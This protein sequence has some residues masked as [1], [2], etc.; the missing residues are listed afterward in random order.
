MNLDDVLTE[1]Q[2][3]FD[4]VAVPEPA[5]GRAVLGAHVIEAVNPSRWVPPQWIVLTTGMRLRR[6]VPAQ[7][8]LVAELSEGGAVA[9]GFGVGIVFDEIPPALLDEARKRDFAVF[10]VPEHTPFREIVR[11]VD[12]ALLSQDLQT[13]RRSASITDGLVQAL[14]DSPPEPS[15]VVRLSKLLHCDASLYRADGAVVHTSGLVADAE[16]RWRDLRA[17]P[18]SHGPVEVVD[19]DGMFAATVTVDGEISHWLVLGVSRG[20]LAVPLILRALTVATKLL[21]GLL[22]V[23]GGELKRRRIRQAELLLAMVSLRPSASEAEIEELRDRALEFGVDVHQR[24]RVVVLGRPDGDDAQAC[25]WRE[26]VVRALAR[27]RVAHL[28]A[29]H[30]STVAL[31]L[32]AD[33]GTRALVASLATG[34]HPLCAGTGQE[35]DDPGS[36]RASYDGARLALRKSFEGGP[37]TLVGYEE[38][39]LLTWMILEVGVAEAERRARDLLA[40]LHDQEYL[41]ETL[42]EYLRNALSIPATARVLHVHENSV[43]HRLN[44]AKALLGSELTSVPTLAEIHIALLLRPDDGE[45]AQPARKTSREP[46]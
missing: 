45:P 34:D 37:G 1:E 23:R 22:G 15:L 31:W 26:D 28:V 21:E 3:G 10:A 25:R 46:V 44:R 12:G 5:L 36:L 30:E 24:G 39:D 43:R 18:L 14:G 33:T 35:I 38:L 27:A 32:P 42:R 20:S 7:R 6:N 2:Y 8:Q 4:A 29:V 17:L 9:L 16:R 41:I 40:P 13:F 11:F 19:A